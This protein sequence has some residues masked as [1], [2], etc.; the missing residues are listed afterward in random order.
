MGEG[1]GRQRNHPHC[2]DC[3][4]LAVSTSY[5]QQ[6]T[7]FPHGQE[8]HK[9]AHRL[10]VMLQ[11]AAIPHCQDRLNANCLSSCAGAGWGGCVVAL[12]HELQADAFVEALQQSYYSDRLSEQASIRQC[13]FIAVPSAGAK[14]ELTRS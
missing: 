9:P 14:V 4:I 8:T 12:V 10:L 11:L 2:T 13:L 3:V 5:S 7:A 6:T 1:G